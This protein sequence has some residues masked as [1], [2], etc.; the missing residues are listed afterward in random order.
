MTSSSILAAVHWATGGRRIA[1]IA[2]QG[3]HLGPAIESSCFGELIVTW[4]RARP[5]DSST[6]R[7]A[8][9][10]WRIRHRARDSATIRATQ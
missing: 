6:R 5:S 9:R 10:T 4:L 1:S 2:T 7:R 8:S 3:D